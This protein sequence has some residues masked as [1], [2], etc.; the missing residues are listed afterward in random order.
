MLGK[1]KLG[2][3]K[4]KYFGALLTDLSNTFDCISQNHILATLHTYDFSLRALTLIHSYLTNKKQKIRVN[5]DYSSWEEILF[6]VPQ[7]SIRLSGYIN[8]LFSK[9][10]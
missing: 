4:P 5:G 1:W 2:V 7:G 8:V 10:F 9:L 3:D 6:G